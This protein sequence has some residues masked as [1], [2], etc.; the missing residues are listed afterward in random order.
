M[1]ENWEYIPYS[2]ERYKISTIGEVYDCKH[3]RII[4]P[5]MSG[6]ERRNY[7]QVTLYIEANGKHKKVTKRVHSLMAEAFLGFV[8]EGSRNYVV[9]HIDNDPLNNNLSNLQVVTMSEN[10]KRKHNEKYGQQLRMF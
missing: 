4:N 3:N 5:H 9:D 8:Y 6:V 1:S 7:P 10:N 2:N